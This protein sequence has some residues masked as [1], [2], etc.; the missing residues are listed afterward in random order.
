MILLEEGDYYIQ[1]S[2]TYE[3]KKISKYEFWKKNNICHASSQKTTT[4]VLR[5]ALR[6]ISA[7]KREKQLLYFCL[8]F[9]Q[10]LLFTYSANPFRT[11][12]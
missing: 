11:V 8:D 9:P 6:K 7:Q 1:G 2:K 10:F 3:K 5:Q 12:R 4:L